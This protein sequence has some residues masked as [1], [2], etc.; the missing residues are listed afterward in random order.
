MIVILVKQID[1]QGHS[2]KS[3]TLQCM[4]NRF[5]DYQTESH[6]V[7]FSSIWANGKNIYFTAPKV[8]SPDMSVSPAVFHFH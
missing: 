8:F 3:G 5:R 1:L 6:I 7:N 4:R 2:H